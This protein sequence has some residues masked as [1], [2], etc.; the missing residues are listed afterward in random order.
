MPAAAR[1]TDNT[2]HGNPLAPGPGSPTVLIGFMPAWRALPSSV[3][4]AVDAIS[5]AM[6]SFM[7]KP[8]MTPADAAADIAQISQK[9]TE[10][11]AKAAAEGAPGAAGAA[12]SQLA[13]LN[14]TNVSLTTAW[15]SAS[16]APGG[17]PA[18]NV[19]YTEGIQ[20]AA[21]AAASA[22]MSAMAGI[23][24]MH[25]CP[26]PVPVPPHGPGFVTKGSGSVIVENL[27]LARQG[28]KVMEACGGADPI[29]AGCA[30]VQ[31]GD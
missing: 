19:A 18:A 1:V 2:A 5:N 28:D 13:T 6:Q 14:S 20:A 15:T 9:L 29:A 16:A 7:T 23:A 21:A 11:G 27:S 12:A 22:V 30:S 26:V 17:Q 3:G 8:T 10:G 25:V 24:D 4:A 31:V